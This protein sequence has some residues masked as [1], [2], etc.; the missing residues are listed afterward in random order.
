MPS[1]FFFSFYQIHD[2][3]IT[4]SWTLEDKEF[5]FKFLF[6]LLLD[7]YLGEEMSLNYQIHILNI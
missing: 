7:E 4:L 2:C 5:Y 1:A 6:I 3:T